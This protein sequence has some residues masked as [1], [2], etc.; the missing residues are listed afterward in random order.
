MSFQNI[1]GHERPIGILRAGLERDA[2]AHAYLF[3]GEEGIGKRLLAKTLAKAA[4][5]LSP[6]AARPVP[7]A[8][9][10]ESR[11]GTVGIT[12]RDACGECLSCRST[13]SGTHPDVMILAPGEGVIKI[14]QIRELQEQMHL[15]PISGRLRFVI[16]DDAESMNAEAANAL[17]KALEEPPDHTVMILITS[18]PHALLSTV[19]SRCQKIRFNPLNR[20]QVIALLKQK[21]A[22]PEGR[23]ARFA[24]LSLGRMGQALELDP[25]S[26]EREWSRLGVLLSE[27]SPQGMD[28]LLDF[29]QEYGRH[30]ERTEQALQWIGLWLRDLLV[31]KLKA[32]SPCL[33]L[34]PSDPETLEISR[35]LE[36]EDLMRFSALIDWIWKAMVRNIN[37]PLALEVLLM[38][39]RNTVSRTA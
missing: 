39:I 22:H 9:K 32:N 10:P 27:R 1:L 19:V 14:G 29:A 3:F 5:C 26:L 34:D 21:H 11:L 35:R 37:R 6:V 8:N 28:G 30:R 7:G 2:L 38:Q 13:E 31:L 16:V 24:S 15:K 23:L 17:L 33:I 36:I 20:D 25:E 18:R 12:G 4:N